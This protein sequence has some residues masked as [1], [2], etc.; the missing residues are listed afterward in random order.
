MV[1]DQLHGGLGQL[2]AR[3]LSTPY[4]TQMVA[5][6]YVYRQEALLQRASDAAWSYQ[7]LGDPTFLRRRGE[8]MI[9]LTYADV[10]TYVKT[11][12]K[13][14]QAHVLLVRPGRSGEV[15]PPPPSTP[16]LVSTGA[17]V[18]GAASALRRRPRPSGPRRAPALAGPVARSGRA[19]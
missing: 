19:G 6:D 14:E 1:V 15:E 17:V 10:A 13:D 18:P 8:R 2:S 9:R 3:G 5:T 7:H 16:Q 4:L 12:L 11:F